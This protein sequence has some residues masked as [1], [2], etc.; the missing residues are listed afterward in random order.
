[1][2]IEERAGMVEGA[3][4]VRSVTPPMAS[5]AWSTVQLFC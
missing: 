4:G 5:V 3:A 1:M 2:G